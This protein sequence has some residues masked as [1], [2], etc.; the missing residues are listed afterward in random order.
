MGQLFSGFGGGGTVPAPTPAPAPA[1]APTSAPP[2]LAHS[3]TN[4]RPGGASVPQNGG[5]GGYLMPARTQAFLPAIGAGAPQV[6]YGTWVPPRTAVPGMAAQSA[7]PGTSWGQAAQTGFVG[8]TAPSARPYNPAS[9][10]SGSARP[11]TAAELL[12]SGM[13]SADFQ[14]YL[15]S[16][17]PVTRRSAFIQPTQPD[18]LAPY[19]GG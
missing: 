12:R 7:V 18:M 15:R 14:A 16:G 6:G 8:N 10:T 17:S 1:P 13:S 3:L 2:G 19:W 4:M 5:L 9:L 11:P